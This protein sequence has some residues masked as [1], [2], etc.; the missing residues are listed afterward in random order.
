MMLLR[1]LLSAARAILIAF[2]RMISSELAW[3]PLGHRRTTAVAARATT[4]TATIFERERIIFDAT[5]APRG[6]PCR[7]RPARIRATDA[8][9]VQAS[10]RI[11]QGRPG[12]DISADPPEKA[13]P[14]ALLRPTYAVTLSFCPF[15][16]R[17]NDEDSIGQA[18]PGSAEKAGRDVATSRPPAAWRDDGEA[19]ERGDVPGS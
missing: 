4:S 3:E 2:C 11:D 9:E 8:P 15:S 14:R 5:I 12:G 1:A 17:R 13:G 10:E 6:H 7:L 19:S 16:T 18:R